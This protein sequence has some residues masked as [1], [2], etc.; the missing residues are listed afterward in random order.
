MNKILSILIEA[1]LVGLI[2]TIIG[3]ASAKIISLL[4]DKKSNDFEWNKYFV[5]EQ[6]LFLTGFLVHIFCQIAG[7]NKYYCTHGSF[8]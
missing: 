4:Y 7:I 5:M 8:N 6:S 1:L 2:T 3:S